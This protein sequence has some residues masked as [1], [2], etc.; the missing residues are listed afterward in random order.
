MQHSIMNRIEPR[1][2]SAVFS[3]F[4]VSDEVEVDTG[5]A[6]IAIGVFIKHV[7]PMFIMHRAQRGKELCVGRILNGGEAEGSL[8][9]ALNAWNGARIVIVV[10]VRWCR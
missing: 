1:G 9:D 5:N 10:V 3:Y 7:S 8:V 6:R 4:M 2:G